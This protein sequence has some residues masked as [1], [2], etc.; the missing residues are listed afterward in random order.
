MDH[1]HEE[2]A[3]ET[4][5]SFLREVKRRE[6]VE[7]HMREG[8]NVVGYWRDTDDLQ[9]MG[10]SQ[11]SDIIRR[12]WQ[13]PYFGAVPYI[14]AM[15]YVDR[16]EDPYGAD[17]GHMIVSYFLGNATRWRGETAKLIKAELRRR[18][19]AYRNY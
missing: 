16:L 2:L 18:L 15:R 13:D 1:L 6:W 19:A 8:E 12:D 5:L 3:L 4:A 11:I 9:Q 7:P 10:L 14:D 17:D